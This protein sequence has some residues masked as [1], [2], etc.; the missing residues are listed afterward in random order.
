MRVL[1][2]GAAGFVGR[3]TL[4]LLKERHDV[5]AFDIQTVEGCLD[6]IE[7][8]VL[9][10]TT[11]G[12]IMAGHDAVVNTIMAPNL[13]YGG[14]GLGFTTNVT[15]VY[16]LLEA[17]RVHGIQ[18]FVHTSSGAVHEGYPRPPETF[19]TYDLYPLKASGPYALSKIMQEELARN[20]HQQHGM[21]IAVIRPWGIIDSERMV[22]T[23]GQPVT[24]FYWGAIDRRDVASALVCALEADSIGYECFYVMA[25]P[26]GYRA[27][28]VAR[29]EE[30]LG[31][32][33]TITFDE[34]L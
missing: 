21:S 18:R 2:T 28:D 16:N 12:A 32:K 5:T 20:F 24:G 17:A 19:L 31:W 30:R 22:T 13:T 15:G 23:D 11:V 6:A 3:I 7:G 26:G 1:L 10:Y 25:T 14:S 27:T 9:D 29:T 33:P 4:D 34:D 8:D